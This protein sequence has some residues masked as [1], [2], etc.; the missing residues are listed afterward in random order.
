MADYRNCED[1]GSGEFYIIGNLI[2]CKHCGTTYGHGFIRSG[3][4][5]KESSM[6]GL[7]RLV[8]TSFDEMEGGK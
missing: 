3:E 8:G 4:V 1:C 5:K 2:V 6:R 7:S